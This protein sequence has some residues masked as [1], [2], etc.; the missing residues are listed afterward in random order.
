MSK[1]IRAEFFRLFHT[2]KCLIYLIGCTAFIL[3]LAVMNGLNNINGNLASHMDEPGII[4]FF[5]L[6]MLPPCIALVTGQLYSKGKVGMYE[7][8]AGNKIHN[9]IFSKVFTDGI[10]FWLIT[11]VSSTGFYIFISLKN[12]LG[13]FSTPGVRF[14]IIA[15]LLAHISIISVMIT[16]SERSVGTGVFLTWFRFIM[17]DSGL[18][19]FISFILGEM[20]FDKLSDQLGYLSLM[21][22]LGLVIHIEM[23]I[24]S[25]FVLHTIFDF[26]IEFIFWYLLIYRGMKKRKYS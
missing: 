4:L 22:K 3:T 14:M 24:D 6:M 21:N 17:F 15:I 1:L 26:V 23:P 9:L 7:I 19:M 5:L 2:K 25:T 11:L 20:G 18:L 10:V 16:L 13:N 12:G 8:M